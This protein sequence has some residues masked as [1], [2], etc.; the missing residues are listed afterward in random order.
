MCVAVWAGDR[1]RKGNPVTGRP[2]AMD[3]FLGTG[4]AGIWRAQDGIPAIRAKAGEK[5][6]TLGAISRASKQF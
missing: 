2:L 4:R 5:G 3:Q 1:E 6:I